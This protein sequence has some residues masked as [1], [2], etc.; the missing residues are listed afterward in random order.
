MPLAIT[1]KRLSIMRPELMRRLHTIVVDERRKRC[2]IGGTQ[3]LSYPLQ[4]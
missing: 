4:D 1:V 2:W 3:S